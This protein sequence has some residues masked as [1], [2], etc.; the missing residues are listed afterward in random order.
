MGRLWRLGIVVALVAIACRAETNV[1]LEI[2]EDGSGT[3]T[4]EL[5]L[6]QEL[7]DLLA[8][9]TGGSGDGIIP[10]FDLDVPGLDGNPLESLDSRV[11]GDMTFYTNT[12][13]F[14]TT[15][16]LERLIGDAGG[17]NSF[18][19]FD[20]TIDGDIVTLTANA[21][22]PG[23]L[24]DSGDLPISLDIIEQAFEASI[25][26]GMPGTVTERNA[27][28]VLP[29][30]RLRWEI[31]LRDG[32]DVRA[33][34]DLSESSFP[35][36]IVIVIVVAA[37]GLAGGLWYSRRSSARPAAAIAATAPP[38]DPRGFTEPA[39]AVLE[40]FDPF[41]EPQEPPDPA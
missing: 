24:A 35:W 18:E 28:E 12:D 32:V 22:A 38:P 13:T 41:A 31:S 36:W 17:D 33:V 39:E 25:I 37:L 11:E 40:P 20:V 10:G 8:G 21:G 14:S 5:G 30:G 26:V 19:T 3:Y 23:D 6:D 16:E 4:V 15:D 7:Q 1:V 27:D 9:F 34:S 2:R 29:D